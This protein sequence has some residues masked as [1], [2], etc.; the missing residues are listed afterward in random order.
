MEATISSTDDKEKVGLNI[1]IPGYKDTLQCMPHDPYDFWKFSWMHGG[2]VP[3][4]LTG[5]FTSWTEAEKPFKKF[6]AAKKAEDEK[7]RLRAEAEEAK[8]KEI[9]RVSEERRA[10]FEAKKKAPAKKVVKED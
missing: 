2:E 1:D 6:M 7:D 4:T 3:G 9:V 10:E 5:E 8:E